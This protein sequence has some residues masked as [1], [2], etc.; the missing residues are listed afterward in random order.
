M[1]QSDASRRH[2]VLEVNLPSHRNLT[3]K[4]STLLNGH[5]TDA[6]IDSAA[7][8]TLVQENLFSKIF[9]PRN[10]GPMCVL[11]GI[12][13]EPV[14]GQLV[15]D[16]PINIGTQTFLHTVCVAPIK[17]TCLLGLDFLTATGSKL[18]L[19]KN[20]LKI[21]GEKVPVQIE[22]SPVL[23][24]SKVNVTK[25]TVIPPNTVGYI[26]VHLDE[27]MDCPFIFEPSPSDKVLLSHVVGDSQ[28]V[29]MTVEVVNDSNSYVTFRKGKSVGHA[30][31]ADKLPAEAPTFNV[32]KTDIEQQGSKGHD[33]L[34]A[35]LPQ[36]L[37]DMYRDNISEL[38]DEQRLK[39]KQLLLEFPDVFSKDDFD[40]GCLNSGV[41]HKINTHD[42]IPIAEKFRRTPLQFQKQEQEY[43]E[44]LLKQGVIEPSASEWAA[45]P[46]L[47]RKKSGELRYCID[48]RALNSKT[49]KDTFNLPL[50]EDC[51]D[52]LYGKRLF[53]VLDLCSGYYQINLELGS[54]DKTSF[55]TRFGSFR[56]TRLPMGLCTAPATFQRAMSL[57]LRGMT[58]EQVIVYLDDIIVIGTDFSDTLAALRNVFI[59]F[60]QYNLKFKARKCR[61]FRREV[62][63]LGKKVS[64]DGIAIS[65][66][67][68]E[69][70][71]EWP[72]P[73]N[74]KQLLSFLGFM[75]YH[76]S[77]IPSFAQVASD[78]YELAHAK[79]FIWTDRH[80][81]S[82]QTL[83]DLAISAPLLSHP[84]PDGMF[85]LD[86][87]ACGSQIAAEL[88]QFQNGDLKPIC[89]ASHVLLKDHRNYCTTRKELLAIVK[90]C[91]QFRHYLLGRSF[92]IRTDHNS[93][94]W[95]TRFRHVEGQLARW[96][97]ELSQYDFKIIHR[98][99]I[100]HLNADGLSRIPDTLQECDC[101][102]AGTEVS[103]LPCGGCSYCR[104]AHRQWARF[105]DDVD[106]V[107]PLAVRDINVQ[108]ADQVP[109]NHH[110]V[111]NWVENMS[112]IQL[113][114]AQFKD[115][116]IGTILA[117]LEH[118]HEPSTRELQLSSPETRALWFS[119]DQL[120][121][122]EGVM[123]YDWS[124]HEGRSRCFVV[125]NSLRRKVLYYCHD[126]K[127]SGHLGQSKTLDRLKEKFYWYGMTRDSDIY[128]KQCSVCNQNKKRNRTPRSPLGTYHAGYPMER[129]HIDI[130]GPFTPSRSGNVYVLVM[131][132]Q[133]TKWT[134]LAALPV[135][136]AELTAKAFL[137]HFIVTFGCP[138]E[139]HSD[140]GRNFQ[141]NLFQT[142]C[143]LL[144]ITKTRTTPYHPS[145]N[146]QAEVF[147]RV[148]LQM[149]RSYLSSGGIRRWDENLPLI[150]MALHSMKN[151][152]TGFSANMMMLGR[153]TTQP[154][155]LILGLP[156]H[157]P[158]DPPNWV[159]TLKRNLSRVHQLARETIGKTQMRQ[160][161]DYDLRIVEHPYEAGDVV[162]LLDSST[163]IGLSKKLR[164]PYTGPFLVTLA[165]PPLYVLED[166][167]RRS[168]IHHD[169]LVPCHD[170]TFPLWLQRKRHELVQTLLIDEDQGM[171]EPEMLDQDDFPIAG[172]FD[173][174][175]I[176]PQIWE[177][178]PDATLPYM[179]GDTMD[180][181]NT[182]V[183][184]SNP[185]DTPSGDDSDIVPKQS[186]AGR[187]I[188]I[189][190]RYRD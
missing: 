44:K 29:S 36:H 83:K 157:I 60:R 57:V 2:D 136:N 41:E 162:Y 15:H 168:L 158:Q 4:V 56:W 61:F 28:T 122:Q 138:L 71:K 93:L 141:S 16:F 121:I 21:G 125:P 185:S 154:I 33:T 140:Q 12:G 161:R 181:D 187:K 131:V 145:G 155:D 43:I 176:L 74:P 108:E 25:R 37:K 183:E 18:D 160:K 30:E 68:V 165:R 22:R 81:V 3:A 11:T 85:V 34:G 107:V 114:E 64:G 169:R 167:K 112:A 189:P 42:E 73:Q 53:C 163:K 46:V 188:N 110:A 190:A 26:N 86:T 170:S 54:R 7:M 100:F 117:W 152:S 14:H 101:Y 105:N 134:E 182:E 120:C 102:R 48:Y 24:I 128:V 47:V 171:D 164:P 6:V 75:N 172:S 104:R 5:T 1:V 132:D 87:D 27:P 153:E 127:N 149:I 55:N 111:S 94:T 180:D 115:P 8:V 72:I 118:C 62:E 99:G 70:V 10:F 130:L 166:R 51:L 186:R 177:S 66:D 63:F 133:F 9:R 174:N 113:R 175:D 139:V 82:F 58:W 116:N 88:S 135:Q 97:E 69:A 17:D 50:I 173:S 31:P 119:R 106:D 109:S 40:L 84:S 91:R 148:I 38:S 179:H 184:S 147:N 159:E 77:H 144:Q 78:L 76:R 126:S 142:F 151:K 98:R 39:F 124:Y 90:F 156:R 32:F 103:D 59:R 146:G 13:E 19:A 80:Q 49:I 45:A 129:V 23:K 123:Y 92:L 79:T 67:K 150:C 89:Y 137:D 95:L 178:D 65:P 20:F 35:Q 52:S 143:Q 96:L